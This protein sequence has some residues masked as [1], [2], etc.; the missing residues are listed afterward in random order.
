MER[1]IENLN[2]LTGRRFQEFRL[3]RRSVA[4]LTKVSE[5]T[6]TDTLRVLVKWLESIDAVE[7]DLHTKVRSPDITP[8]ENSRDVMLET[9]DAETMLAHLERYEYASIRHVTAAL[10]WH[11]MLRM[12]SV[13]A[14]DV[15]DYD[16]E[17][18]SLRL[19]HRPETD[20]PLKNKREGERII[21]VSN[22]VCLVL[23][24]WIREQ[25]P[26][27][28]DDH[29]RNALLTTRSGRIAKSTF[30][31]KCYR[32]TR[33]CEYGQACP[34]D[35]DPNDCEAT[36]ST[37]ASKCPS[38]VSPHPFR[39]GAITHYLQNDVPETVVGDQANVTSEVID[40]HYDQRS[41]KEKMEQR[42][43]YLDSI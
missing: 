41:Q 2:E 5:K 32:M 39:R 25:R 38:S 36:T 23:N 26:E 1:D 4:D 40:K 19:R 33:P 7:Q 10:L 9:D 37:G 8:R 11:T 16:P 14:L 22:D 13:R 42:R 20:T 12:G 24:D 15:E 29:S 27:V 35:R 31:M 28:T 6:Q 18:Q 30:R 34:H 3:W 17:E 21:A 43:G